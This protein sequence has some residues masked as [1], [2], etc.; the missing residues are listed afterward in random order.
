[1]DSGLAAVAELLRLGVDTVGL[2]AGIVA[3][4]AAGRNGGFLLAGLAAFHHD[5]VEKLGRAR[6]VKLY[7]A[8][9]EELER[10]AATT[11]QFVRLPRGASS[12]GGRARPLE[13]GAVPG[14]A[15]RDE[16]QRVSAAAG[17]RVAAPA[18]SVPWPAVVV[19]VAGGL[20]T[21]VAG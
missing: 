21:A 9:A 4:G 8:T 2:D 1:G 13:G 5:A 16:G 18:G 7:R 14:R 19:P 15:R 20:G 3:G 11:P 12:R 17:A 6:A 10:F